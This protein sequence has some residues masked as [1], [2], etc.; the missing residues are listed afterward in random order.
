MIVALIPAHNEEVGIAKTIESLRAQT[1]AP[2]RIIVSADNCTDATV[3]I[4][5]AAGAEVFETLNNPHKKAGA[6]NQALDYFLPTLDNDDFVIILDAD[7]ALSETWIELAIGRYGER[8]GAISGAC[9]TRDHPGVLSLLQRAEYAQGFR[10]V[11]RKGGKVDVLSGAAAIFSVAVLRQLYYLRGNALPGRPGTYYNESS[12]TED[13]EVTLC[14]Q[15]LGYEPRCYKDLV[16]I[17]DIMETVGDL[18]RQR[19]RWQ[20]GTIDTLRDFGYNSVTKRMWGLVFVCYLPILV[21]SLTLFVWVS[22]ALMGTIS[23]QPIWLALLPIFS[24][25]QVITSWRGKSAKASLFVATLLPVWIYDFFKTYIYV[26]AAAGSVFNRN[27][28]WIT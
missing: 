24:L 2:E 19:L 14:L 9:Q 25:D 12:L 26:R 27:K 11:A 3:E 13:F 20:R 22:V 28:V 17:T 21:V 5:L 10:R 18:Y 4:S 16:V 8:T 6:L 15:A 23:F 1:V 7:G